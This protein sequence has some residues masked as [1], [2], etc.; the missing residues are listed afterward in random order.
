[1]SG[2]INMGEPL[3]M[4]AAKS[5]VRQCFRELAEKLH[6]PAGEEGKDATAKKSGGL[7]SKI[8]SD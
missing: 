2:A 1:V 3:L 8:F 4:H 6:S 5:K 7:F